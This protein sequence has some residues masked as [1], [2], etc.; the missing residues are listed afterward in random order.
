MRTSL[1]KIIF[2]FAKEFGYTP[3]ETLNLTPDE[4]EI[5]ILGLS[6]EDLKTKEER[7]EEFKKWT[8]IQKK[9]KEQGIETSIKGLR[10]GE[11]N[12]GKR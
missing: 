3:E 6:G 11:K 7:L 2:L 4:A 8:E 9:M 10:L 1:D 5:L 12:G